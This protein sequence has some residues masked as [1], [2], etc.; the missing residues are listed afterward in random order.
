MFTVS[1]DKPSGLQ[2]NVYWKLSLFVFPE[3]PYKV[4]V[5]LKGFSLNWTPEVGDLPGWFR[6]L[7]PC[8]VSIKWGFTVHKYNDKSVKIHFCSWKTIG[9]KVLFIKEPK[10]CHFLQTKIHSGYVKWL[11]LANCLRWSFLPHRPP[12]PPPA[13]FTAHHFMESPFLLK[14][15]RWR[16]E[17]NSRTFNPWQA[18]RNER[19]M[20][21]KVGRI[22]PICLVTAWV[23]RPDHYSLVLIFTFRWLAT[24][25]FIYGNRWLGY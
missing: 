10:H 18:L 23:Q 2:K 15:H 6:S 21:G 25:S 19:K 24:F 22:P 14:G 13:Y 5:S 8:S 11:F 12:Y 4:S 7:K 1:H 17:L 3:V 20:C 16:E 9:T